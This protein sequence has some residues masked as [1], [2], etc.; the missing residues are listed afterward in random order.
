MRSYRLA[1]QPRT[2]LM[3]TLTHNPDSV[4]ASADCGSIVSECHRHAVTQG[5]LQK[6]RL[7]RL[8]PAAAYLSLSTWTLR[9]I[10][11]RGEL[12]VVRYGEN[13]PW[14]LD[15]RDLDAWVDRH[16]ESLVDSP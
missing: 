16:K 8:K 4:L 10:I 3:A 5:D 6:R 7:L 9:T 11:Q 1:V 13:A 2:K 14:L 12:P 15:I